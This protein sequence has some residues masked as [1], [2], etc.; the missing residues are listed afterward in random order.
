MKKLIIL[1][2]LLLT[3][4]SA[5]YSA[6]LRLDSISTVPSVITAGD[7]AEIILRVQNV[8][9]NNDEP[10]YSYKLEMQ[11]KDAL[12]KENII[13]IDGED[14]LGRMGENEYW[15]SKF[16]VKV[17]EGAPSLDYELAIFIKKYRDNTLISETESSIKISIVGDT[18]FQLDSDDKT[19]N[20]GETK[21]F[22]ATIKNVGGSNAGN[23]ELTFDNSDNIQVLGTN[24]F[25]FNNIQ[26]GK[27][28]E[29][30]ITLYANNNIP[31]RIYNIPVTITYDDQTKT[32]TQKL[33]V[34]V[35][36]GGNIDLRVAN[37]ETTPKEIRPGDNF[38]LVEVD[39]ENSGDDVAKAISTQLIS[40]EFDSSYSDNNNKYVGR[41]NSGSVSTLKYYID[42][43]KEVK[44]GVYDTTLNLNFKNDLDEE[45]SNE[46]NVPIY[47]KEKPILEIKSVEAL[48][49][50]G[51]N[52]EVKVVV[53]NI[54]EEK[55][56]EVDIRL[57]SDSSLP[58]S[59]EERS[60]YLGTVEAGST[61]IAIFNVNVDS[62][63]DLKE[64]S[65]SAFIRARG[66]S[67]IGDNNIYT[68]TDNVDVTVS[69]KAL[70]WLMIIGLLIA[71]LVIGGIIFKSVSSKKSKKNKNS[72]KNS[73]N[74]SN[75]NSNNKKN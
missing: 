2:I 4:V 33:D 23:V 21:T 6:S 13:I 24:V 68:F 12:S 9:D 19:I 37:I 38:V 65:I 49:K 59:I 69:G 63:A 56:Q 60:E 10:E 29:F 75:N 71:I 55:A 64:Y 35:L 57:I 27:E 44:S 54:G 30:Q 25:Y 1:L 61:K 28:K 45:F 31:S 52:M 5:S 22:N 66:D 11:T 3:L 70:N 50:A 40:S 16:R 14:N 74:N 32:V 48:G 47:I 51:G 73:S 46:L 18:F 26:N 15:N 39:I 62:S 58:F 67:E 20:Q 42:I 36:V 17:K 41:L 7:E 8:M 72:N 43:P 34:G 53:E